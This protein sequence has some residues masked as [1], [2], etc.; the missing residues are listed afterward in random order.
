MSWQL[1]SLTFRLKSPLHIGFHEVMLLSRTR[2]Y[3][4]AKPFWGALTAKLTRRLGLTDYE[5]IGEFLKKAMRFSYFYPSVGDKVYA[6]FYTEEGLKFGDLTQID[7]EKCFLSSLTS[8]AIEPDSLTAEDGML[9][10]IEFLSPYTM[11]GKPVFLK[12][13]LWV[14]DFSEGKLFIE[15]KDEGFLIVR[16]GNRIEF[17]E[18][19]DTLQV[20]GERKYGFG[21]LKIKGRP[22]KENNDELEDLG[23]FGKWQGKTSEI[24]LKIKKNQ[25]IWSH[26]KCAN[27][28]R[29]KGSLEPVMGRDW[30]SAKGAGRKLSS[31][32]LCWVPGSV[33]T[34]EV[35]F[36]VTQDF[37]LWEKQ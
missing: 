37:G 32:G 11:N 4:P 27:D 18:L 30:D 21:L 24:L 29:I 14:S 26:V 23:F 25:P 1:Y 33:L 28:L 20:G 34:E 15:F 35:T 17:S 9:H 19:V 3:V 36:K 22:K 12:G 13:L 2:P 6:P 10:E 16:D 7:F 31:Y 5:K 8:A